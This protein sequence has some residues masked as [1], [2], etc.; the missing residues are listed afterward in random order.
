LV[1]AAMLIATVTTTPTVA[2]GQ[3]AGEVGLP[4][5]QRAPAVEIEDLDGNA[6]P[7]SAAIGQR[8]VVIE[9]WATWCPICEELLP[10][11]EAAARRFGDH[12]DFVAVAVGVNQSPRTIRRHLDRHPMPFRV[13]FDRRGAAVRAFKTPTTS[14]VVILGADGRV[15]YTGVGAEQDVEGALLQ[16]AGDQRN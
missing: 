12:A 15:A 4:I 1:R 5:G 6:T 8:P 7:V 2:A 3:A 13:L 10:R 11:M 9:F 16:L 14:Y